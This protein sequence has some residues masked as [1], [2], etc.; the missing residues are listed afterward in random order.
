ASAATVI[1][2]TASS[3]AAATAM[4]VVTASRGLPSLTNFERRAPDVELRVDMGVGPGV[5]PLS[6]CLPLASPS[7]VDRGFLMVGR[8]LFI[9]VSRRKPR[10]ER[11]YQQNNARA[12]GGQRG[13]RTSMRSPQP[14]PGK[15]RQHLVAKIR[16]LVE[17]I[18]EGQRDAAHAGLADAVELVGDA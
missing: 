2:G 6:R 11:S 18:D 12:G 14:A 4:L 15:P 1:S 9:A 7:S 10:T 16:Q 13:G 3:N 17:V 8:R 5:V